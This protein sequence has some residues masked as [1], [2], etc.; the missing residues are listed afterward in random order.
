MILVIY[1]N[2]ELIAFKSYPNGELNLD[3]KQFD[4]ESLRQNEENEIGFRFVNNADFMELL[5]AKRYL[6]SHGIS[7]SLLIHYMPYS[8]MDRLVGKHAFSL[9][10]VAQQ[11]NWM[12]FKKVSVVEPH[13]DVTLKL[14]ERSEAIYPAIHLLPKVEEVVG[15]DRSKD[16]IF[17][18]DA[19]STKRY[20]IVDG[21]MQLT[22]EKKRNFETG[23]IE[24]LKVIGEAPS[25]GFKVIIVDDLSSYGGTFLESAKQLKDLGASEV[26]LLVTHAESSILL[27]K[28]PESLLINGVFT[29]NSMLDFKSTGK[30][31]VY[32]LHDV[33]Q[34][35]EEK[36]KIKK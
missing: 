18:P 2:R 31:T 11:I 21:Y 16:V 35:M 22:A 33:L 30:F 3:E 6:D 26:Y 34:E 1:I 25:N 14:L 27:G 15:F 32:D 8:R 13:S 28:I 36:Y 9:E 19:G 24:S 17:F 23:K 10:Y 7:S 5:F 12:G 20:G 4:L 29:T